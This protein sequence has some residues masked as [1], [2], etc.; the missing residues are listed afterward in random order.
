[1]RPG[2]A[3]RV[4]VHEVRCASCASLLSGDELIDA[5]RSGWL[6]VRTSKGG[7]FLAMPHTGSARDVSWGLGGCVY[8][9][10]DA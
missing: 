10:R 4:V 8:V 1:V 6:S 7:Q 9:G 3:R 2:D 5:A